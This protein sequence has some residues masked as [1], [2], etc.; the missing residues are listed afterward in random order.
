MWLWENQQAE[1][2]LKWMPAILAFLEYDPQPAG[3]T[4]GERLVRFRKARGWS[5]KRLA[6]ALH[7]DPTTL[8]R[9]EL[10]KRVPWGIYLD[11]VAGL[12]SGATV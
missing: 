5:Q 9:W 6:S 8:S 11:R 3:Q 10:G 2:E 12:L 4:T 7:V 1:P